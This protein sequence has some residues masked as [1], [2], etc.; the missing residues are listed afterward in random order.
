MAL[1]AFLLSAAE[2]TFY[3]QLH[4]Q[5]GG[6]V[7]VLDC[8]AVRA[9][10]RQLCQALPGVELHYAL[11]PLPHE[12][13]VATLL[14]EGASFDLA[15]NG[16]VD[17][18]ASLGVPAARCIHSHPIKRQGDI[19]HAL[20]QG[21]STFVVDNVHELAK[22]RPYGERVALLLRVSFPNPELKVDLSKKFGCLPE[23]VAPLLSL[24]R[25][26]GIPMAGLS[27]HVGS[28]VKTAERHAQAI[29]TSLALIRQA[30][31][32]GHGLRVLDIGGGFP[33]SYHPGVKESQRPDLV[34]FCAPIREALAEAP[35]DLRLIAEPG[36]CLVANAVTLV[37]RVMGL[38]ERQGLPWYYLDDGVYG[39]FNGLMFDD[40]AYPLYVEAK[41]GPWRASV[42]AGPTCDSID[43]ISEGLL[44]PE[45]NE[46]D[47]LVARMMGAYSWA[48]ASEFNFFRRA[49]FFVVN[50]E[51]PAVQVA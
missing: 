47:L 41:E 21:V 22:F 48:A 16:E 24:A 37:T 8:D 33:V 46:G 34:S 36:R 15:S 42:L 7:Q 39:S 3:R 13:V 20:A 40:A 14:A 35:A 23:A 28:Q 25:A 18:V 43:V 1:S 12:A 30:R 29:R 11:K 9:N 50:G 6:P 4:D 10:Y 5:L 45:L 27:F 32:E 2:A 17:L 31:A 26:W 19:D 44:L 51:L 49:Q 38:S